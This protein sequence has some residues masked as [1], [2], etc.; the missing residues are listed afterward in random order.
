MA[1][2]DQQG[3]N[4]EA[5]QVPEVETKPTIPTLPDKLSD[6]ILVA[7]ADLEKVERST[8]HR[9]F[10]SSWH[11]PTLMGCIVCF[12]GGVMA[13][14]LGASPRD[15]VHPTDYDFHTQQKLYALNSLRVGMVEAAFDLM[16]IK[17]AK[18]D[19][20]E[21][22]ESIEQYH[23]DPPLFKSQMRDLASRLA[24]TGY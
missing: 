5:A 24:S 12:A 6:L 9:V 17:F 18:D 10:M 19:P 22:G 23:M 8:Q 20:I 14:S 4:Y 7:L 3:Y 2:L 21:M 1:P 13:F 11:D 16:G 15:T